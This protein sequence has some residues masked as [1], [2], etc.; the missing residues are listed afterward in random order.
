MPLAEQ[1]AMQSE[2]TRLYRPQDPSLG[3]RSEQI[4]MRFEDAWKEWV[5]GGPPIEPYLAEVTEA[6]RPVLLP[7][8]LRLDVQLRGRLGDRPTP[9]E[10][11]GRLP[12]HAELIDDVFAEMGTVV[13]GAGSS[14]E[15]G[16]VAPGLSRATHGRR[17]RILRFHARGGLGRVH[18]AHDEELHREVA[19][20]EI[21]ECYADD[22]NSRARF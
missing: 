5:R 20:K 21:Q 18:V 22:P 16:A 10:Y 15:M 11:R 17:F 13:F 4:Y 1:V 7:E 8:L 3:E 12:G 2:S 14:S 9:E 6:E 19:L